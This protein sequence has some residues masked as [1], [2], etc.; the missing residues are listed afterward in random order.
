MSGKNLTAATG[1]LNNFILISAVSVRDLVDNN[2]ICLYFHLE[3]KF[4]CSL[5]HG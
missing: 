3:R 1:R 2:G 5:I 4:L